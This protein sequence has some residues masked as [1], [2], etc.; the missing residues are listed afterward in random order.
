VLP[1]TKSNSSKTNLKE[2][3]AKELLKTFFLLLPKSIKAENGQQQ[4]KLLDMPLITAK[5]IK[6]RVIATSL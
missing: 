4:R 3:Q 6:Q 1:L 5:E 2:E